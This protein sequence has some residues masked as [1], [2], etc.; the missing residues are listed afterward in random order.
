MFYLTQWLLWLLQQYVDMLHWISATYA[1]LVVSTPAQQKRGFLTRLFRLYQTKA[2]SAIPTPSDNF[3]VTLIP[4][5]NDSVDDSLDETPRLQQS[6]IVPIIDIPPP[7]LLFNKASGPTVSQADFEAVLERVKELEGQYTHAEEQ[8]LAD[9]ES[10]KDAKT[11][12]SMQR[13]LQNDLKLAGKAVLEAQHQK[14]EAEKKREPLEKERNGLNRRLEKVNTDAKADRKRLETELAAHKTECATAIRHLNEAKDRVAALERENSL[15]L[16]STHEADLSNAEHRADS[17]AKDKTA[18]REQ[19]LCRL[20]ERAALRNNDDDDDDVPRAAKAPAARF[21]SAGAHKHSHN[22]S[23]S[24]S[25]K[26]PAG[27]PRHTGQKVVQRTLECRV[28]H[29]TFVASNA[30]F[31]HLEVAHQVPR[32][33]KLM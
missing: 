11:A 8:R 2:P 22:G 5:P 23:S 3:N 7:T 28:C 27:P 13:K 9:A 12:N 26:M 1:W 32:R 14:A 10:I 29:R 6:I 19:D 20:H 30:L 33:S 24:A 16:T 4:S 17:L 21:Q 15:R 31:E 25:S 18:P